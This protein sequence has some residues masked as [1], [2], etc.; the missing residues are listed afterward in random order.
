M[1]IKI[2]IG[3]YKALVEAGREQFE[4]EV[5]SLLP[6]VKLGETSDKLTQDELNL[7]LAHAHRKVLHMQTQLARLQVPGCV[8]D[9]GCVREAVTS[10][11]YLNLCEIYGR[12]LLKVGNVIEG[13]L[14][15][16]NWVFFVVY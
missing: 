12:V 3:S 6:E 9:E 11:S 15:R 4:A 10:R 16:R 7:L 1:Q 13:E 5:R 8:R 2:H 14:I